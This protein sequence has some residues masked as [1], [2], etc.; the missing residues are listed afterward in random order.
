MASLGISDPEIISKPLRI[1][2]GGG[3]DAGSLGG[4]GVSPGRGKGHHKKVFI[5]A[6]CPTVLMIKAATPDNSFM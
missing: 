5:L 3:S 2:T 6:C 1:E 4:N